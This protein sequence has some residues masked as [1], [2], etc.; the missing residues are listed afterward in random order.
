MKGTASFYAKT[1]KRLF[2]LALALPALVALLP[3]MGCVAVLVRA[4]L[5]SPVLFRQ[6]RAGL[7]G[8]PFLLYK[9]RTMGK[10]FDKQG[11]KVPDE[12]R[13]G[14]LG[15]FLRSTSIDELPELWNIVLGDMSIVGP[16]PL[17][18][19]Y[20]PYYTKEEARRHEVR[21]GLTGL[22]QVSGRNALGWEDRLAL[23]VEYAST[24]NFFMDI[25]LIVSTA[26]KVVKKSDVEI[27]TGGKCRL[28]DWRGGENVPDEGTKA[29]AN[30][31]TLKER[32]CD[33]S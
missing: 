3:V 6:E 8:R 2:D 21:P 28:D 20:L 25:R 4:K 14:R 7:R 9:F 10:E 22:A 13:T 33:I 24:Y 30:S 11:N 32:K 5:G 31:R 1:G 26:G 19:E 16:R 27:I 12:E 18:V 29:S 17:F 15:R 23:D